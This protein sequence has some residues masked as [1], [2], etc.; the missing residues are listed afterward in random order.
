M[1]LAMIVVG[2]GLAL[3]GVRLKDGS[4]VRTQQGM[5]LLGMG[6]VVAVIGLIIFTIAFAQGFSQGLQQSE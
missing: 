2:A 6:S 4:G 5:I 3:C 1:D